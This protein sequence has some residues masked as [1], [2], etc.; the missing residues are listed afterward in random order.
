MPSLVRMRLTF[1]ML[2]FARSVA[3][4][5]P[6]GPDSPASSCGGCR[7]AGG[8]R[9]LGTR[10]LVCPPRIEAARSRRPG[11]LLERRKLLA[12]EEARLGGLVRSDAQ[13]P[14]LDPGAIDDD[15]D[16][17]SRPHPARQ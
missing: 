8:Y 16:R 2:P 10:W 3:R 14:P 9:C 1:W 13:F 4:E 17:K 6:S 11:Q 5:H 12:R 7:V 15:Q